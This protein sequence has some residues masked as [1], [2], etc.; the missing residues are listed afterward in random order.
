MLRLRKWLSRFNPQRRYYLTQYLF[1]VR[2]PLL[3]GLLLLLL[4]WVGPALA[5]TK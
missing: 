2:F 4:P 1:F 3:F 5:P